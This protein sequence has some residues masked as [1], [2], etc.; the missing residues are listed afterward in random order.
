MDQ[1]NYNEM[2]RR[3]TEGVISEAAWREYCASILDKVLT[4]N[5][6][7]FVRLKHR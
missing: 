5:K 4:D 1:I 6:D 3:F 2:Y 7:V